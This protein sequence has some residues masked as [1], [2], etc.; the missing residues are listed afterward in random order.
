RGSHGAGKALILAIQRVSAQRSAGQGTPLAVP[1]RLAVSVYLRGWSGALVLATARISGDSVVAIHAG[2]AAPGV[3]HEEVSLA[4]MH[5]FVRATDR[6][7]GELP[8]STKPEPYA[9]DA[10]GNPARRAGAD[11][12]RARRLLISAYL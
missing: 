8:A 7:A 10:T 5:R 3:F 1:F 6:N 2:N 12:T 11:R 4:A 9:D